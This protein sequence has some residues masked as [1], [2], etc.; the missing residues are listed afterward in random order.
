VFAQSAQLDLQTGVLGTHA[1]NHL[2]EQ[3]GSD[4]LLR[5]KLSKESGFVGRGRRAPAGRTVLAYPAGFCEV[6]LWDDPVAR[7]PEQVNGLPFGLGDRI[8][9][10]RSRW[11]RIL[12]GAIP[13][14]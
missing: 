3:F 4:V 14:W 10:V 1:T 2:L 7:C 11:Q 6:G 5:S 12:D 9:A 13:V 8:G